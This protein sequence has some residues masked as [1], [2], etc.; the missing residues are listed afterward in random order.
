MN[1]V[2]LGPENH[3]YAYGDKLKGFNAT[4]VLTMPTDVLESRGFSEKVS[5]RRWFRKPSNN[6]LCFTRRSIP[7]KTTFKNWSVCFK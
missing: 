7:G 2:V 6:K 1:K 3:G 4:W 5:S